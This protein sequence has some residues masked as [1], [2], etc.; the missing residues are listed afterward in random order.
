MASS[1]V[2]LKFLEMLDEFSW[3]DETRP[4]DIGLNIE[5]VCLKPE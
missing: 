3:Q 4:E 5:R 1:I 2:P